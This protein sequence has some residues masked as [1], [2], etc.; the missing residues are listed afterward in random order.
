MPFL[1]FLT[2]SNT[3]LHPNT[4]TIL[5]Y[6]DFVKGYIVLWAFHVTDVKNR[7]DP[8]FLDRKVQTVQT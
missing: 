7:N 5:I 6:V 8:K 2:T 3:W 4:K 1:P